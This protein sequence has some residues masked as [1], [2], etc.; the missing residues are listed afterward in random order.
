MQ[1]STLEVLVLIIPTSFPAANL[2]LA[3]PW[4]VEHKKREEGALTRVPRGIG[5]VANLQ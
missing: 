1:E 2:P 4:F 5:P 3:C